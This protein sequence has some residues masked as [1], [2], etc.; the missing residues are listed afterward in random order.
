MAA[1]PPPARRA[2]QDE[3]S[4]DGLISTPAA[5][6]PG[7]QASRTPR[8]AA[9]KTPQSVL[10]TGARMQFQP[11][12]AALDQF[13]V[14]SSKDKR[15]DAGISFLDASAADL[16]STRAIAARQAKHV[17]QMGVEKIIS[18]TGDDVTEERRFKPKSGRRRG[19]GVLRLDTGKSGE[20][21]TFRSGGLPS[22][23]RERGGIRFGDEDEGGK[24]ADTRLYKPTA[25][26]ADHF[27]KPSGNTPPTSPKTWEDPPSP[28]AP[29][30]MRPW[31]VRRRQKAAAAAGGEFGLV[32]MEIRKER[33]KV[34]QEVEHHVVTQMM[35]MKAAETQRERAEGKLQ[36]KI[37][38]DSLLLA[39]QQTNQIGRLEQAIAKQVRQSQRE[40]PAH[41]KQTLRGRDMLTQMHIADAKTAVHTQKAAAVERR[42]EEVELGRVIRDQTKEARDQYF[43]R[44]QHDLNIKRLHVHD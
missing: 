43:A 38:R 14:K 32:E 15:K 9:P 42:K 17:K 23:S 4:W 16:N 20:G 34:I 12:A 26:A 1:R 33:Q 5:S 21:A 3:N 39:H 18:V 2:V 31:Q 24:I 27:R 6:R 28:P 22:P 30:P 44:M 11:V 41:V 36:A 40:P 35:K 13:K 7:S 10:K 25:S 8:S 37:A 29:F 19:T